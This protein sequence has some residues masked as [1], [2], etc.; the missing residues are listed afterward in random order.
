MYSLP[1]AAFPCEWVN[2][3]LCSTHL[4]Q[5][6]CQKLCYHVKCKFLLMDRFSEAL[7][8]LSCFKLKQLKAGVLCCSRTENYNSKTKSVKINLKQNDESGKP[9]DFK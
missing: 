5:K 6:P 8:T 1:S 7:C 4:E 2:C 9:R 3:S